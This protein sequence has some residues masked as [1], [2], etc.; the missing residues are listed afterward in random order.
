MLTKS[1]LGNLA[2]TSEPG[3]SGIEASN[4]SVQNMRGDTTDQTPDLDLDN[5]SDTWL[6][7]CLADLDFSFLPEL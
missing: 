5:I 1:P 7:E 2:Q 4:G 6:D 3:N